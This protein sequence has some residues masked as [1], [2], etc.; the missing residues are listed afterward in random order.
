MLRVLWAG[1]ER[2]MEERNPPWSGK[3]H[4]AVTAEPVAVFADADLMP[5]PLAR[6]EDAAPAQLMLPHPLS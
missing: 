4:K 6:C 5:E 1:K 3:E 2:D